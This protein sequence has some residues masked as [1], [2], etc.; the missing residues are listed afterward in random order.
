MKADRVDRG[1]RQPT[2]G[3]V[4]QC[5]RVGV[6]QPLAV[7]PA[8]GANASISDMNNWLLAQ[9]GRYPI[10]CIG[11]RTLRTSFCFEKGPLRMLPRWKDLKQKYFEMLKRSKRQTVS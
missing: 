2:V 5:F 8:A 3:E 4:R 9:M 7:A 11:L 6:D 10:S 1:Q